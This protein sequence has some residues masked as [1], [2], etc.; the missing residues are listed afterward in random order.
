MYRANNMFATARIK[1]DKTLKANRV[2]FK[3]LTMIRKY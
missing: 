3:G 2:T 1:S